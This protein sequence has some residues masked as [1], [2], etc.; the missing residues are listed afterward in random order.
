[1]KPF[2][3]GILFTSFIVAGC[4][5][6]S[7]APAPTATPTATALPA[8]TP[9]VSANATATVLPLPSETGTATPEATQEA[10]RTLTTIA[11]PPGADSTASTATPLLFTPTSTPTA[12]TTGTF[13]KLADL[14]PEPLAAYFQLSPDAQW[15][16]YRLLPHATPYAE[17]AQPV[18]YGPGDP[19]PEP[20]ILHHQHIASGTVWEVTSDCTTYV[21]EYGWLTTGQLL[22][23]EQGKLYLSDPDGQNRRDLAA[24]D[25]IIEILGQTPDDLLILRGEQALWR[26]YMPEG[27]W[28]E[29]PD[30]LPGPAPEAELATQ[31][32]RLYLTVD[33]TA[34][35]AS[36]TLSPMDSPY[37]SD[38]VILYIP[39]APGSAPI[40]VMPPT[41][42]HFNVDKGRAPRPPVPFPGTGYW[43]P[44]LCYGAEPWQSYY[45]LL[46]TTTG[47]FLPLDNLLSLDGYHHDVIQLSPDHRWLATHI[48]QA[49]GYIAPGESRP[50]AM[51]YVAPT[52][53]LANGEILPIEGEII[54][55][56]PDPPM[57]FAYGGYADVESALLR[58][59]LA[60]HTLTTPFDIPPGFGAGMI[61]SESHS[62]ITRNAPGETYINTFTLDGTPIARDAPPVGLSHFL[63]A[64]GN[65]L[66]YIDS[67][68]F[69]AYRTLWLYEVPE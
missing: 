65:R 32:D 66:Y 1:M 52:D 16:A 69:G 4:G 36:Y 62:F 33:G 18:R 20:A 17:S 5:I 26:L 21:C 45:C 23:R 47:T 3:W 63:H 58:Y 41:H 51:V 46:D 29:I 11:T 54:G 61:S 44:E 28:D 67:G 55:W 48:T 12:P 49:V 2:L 22:W 64:D 60:A 39:F 56:L 30:P 6:A 43:M 19:T 31:A 34:A 15:L 35:F 37:G 50:R 13:T 59:D 7:V 9:V 53:D 14:T 24:P 57:L 68:W 42:F 38:D 8:T 27:E 40:T 25:A 10:T